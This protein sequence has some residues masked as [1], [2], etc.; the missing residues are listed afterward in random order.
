MD[1]I[2]RIIGDELGVVPARISPIPTAGDSV[3]AEV[4]LGDRVVF[5]KEEPTR[6]IAARLWIEERVRA[7]GVPVPRTV[8]SRLEPD[9]RAHG[10]TITERVSG[11][12]IPQR[13]IADA[14]PAALCVEA[15]RAIRLLHSIDVPGVGWLAV[16]PEARGVNASWS[17][18]MTDE[19]DWGLDYVAEHGLLDHALIEAQRAAACAAVPSWD[20]HGYRCLLHG[21]LRPDHIFVDGERI[22]AI[23][24]FQGRVG[25]PVHDIAKWSLLGGPGGLDAFLDGYE[26]GD[27]IVAGIEERLSLYETIWATGIIRWFHERDTERAHLIPWLRRVVEA[28]L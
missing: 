10:W 15:G 21:D 12:P 1:P 5:F 3:V 25:D 7:V 24:D 17:A 2:A 18:M 26:P 28:R 14:V 8:A 19:A 11:A 13:S 16:D 6:D 22:T 23:I 4:D 27:A 20:A 9:P